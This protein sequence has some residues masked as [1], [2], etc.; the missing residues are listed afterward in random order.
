MLL[1]LCHSGDM[2]AEKTLNSSP[3]HATSQ[4]W[5]M[6]PVTDLLEQPYP[7]LPNWGEKETLL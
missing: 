2:T 1:P 6:G 7:H 4:V 5:D 3:G